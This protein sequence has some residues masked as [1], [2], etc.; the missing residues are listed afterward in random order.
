VGWEGENGEHSRAREGGR[1]EGGRNGGARRG[2][3]SSSH[4]SRVCLPIFPA[5][6]MWIFVI[7][8]PRRGRGF[9]SRSE[10][11]FLISSNEAP[12]AGPTAVLIFVINF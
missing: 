5:G 3:A 4:R 7:T 9:Y 6:A 1:L 10:R 12:H 8:E 2:C 11:R